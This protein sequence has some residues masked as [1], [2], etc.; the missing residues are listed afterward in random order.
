[1]TVP[2]LDLSGRVAIVTGGSRSIG[3]A[4]ALALAQVGADVAVAGRDQAALEEVR[5][6]IKAAT[7]RRALAVLCDVGAPADIG[8]MVERCRSELGPP[9]VLVANAGIFQVWQPSE[10][11]GL[12]EWD[13]VT[14]VDL[15]GVMLSCLAAGRLMLERGRGSIVT[16]SS[17]AGQ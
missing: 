17:I 10:E 9:D 15:R 13:R 11:L 4:T 12:D 16:I 6:V 5:A 7:G 8:A 2:E 14:D 1:M 3:R